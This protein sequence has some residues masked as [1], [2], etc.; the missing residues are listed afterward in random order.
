MDEVPTVVYLLDLNQDVL[1]YIC[2]Y[3]NI[4]SQSALSQ[5]CKSIKDKLYHPMFSWKD[6]VF[7][8]NNLLNQETVNSLMQRRVTTIK[9]HVAASNLIP[10]LETCLKI[11]T[12]KSLAVHIEVDAA[13]SDLDLTSNQ[14]TV[15]E[16]SCPDVLR[17][18]YVVAYPGSAFLSTPI[19]ENVESETH[20]KIYERLIT[21]VRNI[22][23]INIH[24]Y[25]QHPLAKDIFKMALHMLPMVT[26][27]EH[28]IFSHYTNK[29]CTRLDTLS[30][31]ESPVAER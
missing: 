20:L 13:K 14:E 10:P 19:S 22:S 30:A 31:S 5:T 25:M 28:R 23:I 29:S 9:L 3:L 4:A 15:Q 24:S 2:G 16:S 6:A 11:E 26:D 17:S 18:L 7:I 12:L 1:C 8:C 27:F 21:K